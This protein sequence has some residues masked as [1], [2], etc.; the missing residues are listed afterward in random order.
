[1][2]AT[3]VFD[4]DG[5]LV[6]TLPDLTA[7]L[8]STL[9]S[10]GLPALDADVALRSVH[11]GLESMVQAAVADPALRARV[12]AAFEQA[13]V[14]RCADASRPYPGVVAALERCA[15]QDIALGVCTNKG[16]ALARKV[17][18]H[19]GL[20]AFF[21]AVIGADTCSRRK[22]DAEPLLAAIERAGGERASAVLVG[23]SLIDVQCARAAGVPCWLY[24]PGYGR[25]APPLPDV[26]RVLYDY[27]ELGGSYLP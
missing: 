9:G 10:H 7:A 11:G 19:L 27:A 1:M 3:L 6:D 8:N 22:P 24:A 18:D 5:T 16:E 15:R 14:A 12:L 26:A 20:L 21:G 13:Y 17:L 25:L 2:A 4:L 23:D